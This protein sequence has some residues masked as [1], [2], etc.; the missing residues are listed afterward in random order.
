MS[1]ITHFPFGNLRQYGLDEELLILKLLRNF[2]DIHTCK[3][4]NKKERH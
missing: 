1:K 3:G 4:D 2:S